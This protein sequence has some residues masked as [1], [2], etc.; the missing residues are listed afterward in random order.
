[1]DGKRADGA[2]PALVDEQVGT[3][4][5]EAGVNR[6]QAAGGAN[7]CI[8]QQGQR[9]GWGD[10][11]TGDRAGRGV[12]GERELAVLGALYPARSG[13]VIRERGGSD[14]RQCPS[15]ESLNAETVPAPGPAWASD[16]YS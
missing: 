5:A 7:L 2:D 14:G 9:A 4:L 6:A 10:R 13:L 8:G 1:V 11:V 12:H 16:T 15:E 3:V